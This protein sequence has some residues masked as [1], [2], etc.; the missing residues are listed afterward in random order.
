MF[1]TLY[2]CPRTVG[3]H[4]NGPLR[5][6][7]LRY[8]EHLAAQGAALRTITAA[9]GIIYRAAIWMKLD[10]S[11]PVERKD[12]ERAAERWAHRS[13]RNANSRGPEQ[14]DKEFRQT[15]CKWLRFAGR[16]R[17]SDRFGSAPRENRCTLPLHGRGAGTLAGYHRNRS[18]QLGKVFQAHPDS[19]TQQSQNRR[20]GAILGSADALRRLWCAQSV[21]WPGQYIRVSGMQ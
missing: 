20:C 3:R 13:Y 10:E 5:E 14:T 15:R 6:S 2:R 1:K 9:A 18:T 8:L 12:V 16:L 19:T 11:G 4:D 21:C 17:E 7:R